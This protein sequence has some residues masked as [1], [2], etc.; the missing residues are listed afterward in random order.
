MKKSVWITAVIMVIIFQSAYS[1]TC[2]INREAKLRLCNGLTERFIFSPGK[3]KGMVQKY[4]LGKWPFK[5][6]MGYAPL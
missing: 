1:N 6:G 5:Q 4:G 2:V 3:I